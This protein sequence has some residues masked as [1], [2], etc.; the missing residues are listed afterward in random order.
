MK[1]I[2]LLLILI[3]LFSVC[4][5][6]DD[7]N[8]NINTETNNN[9][10]QGDSNSNTSSVISDFELPERDDPTDSSNNT[11]TDKDFNASHDPDD[12][13]QNLTVTKNLTLEVEKTIHTSS[14]I[15][16]NIVLRNEKGKFNYYNDFF[17]QKYVNGKWEYH[18]TLT[19]SIDYKYYIATSQGNIEFIT[20]DLRKNYST[21]LPTGTY[22]FIQESDSGKLVS[23]SFEIVDN[24]IADENQ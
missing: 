4:A 21:P 16:I 6:G 19:D 11:S 8:T 12:N 18:T 23:N 9:T 15:M 24:I 14:V 10:T 13:Q 3:M 5:C 17:L 20:Y 2:A 22:R 7:T 1:K